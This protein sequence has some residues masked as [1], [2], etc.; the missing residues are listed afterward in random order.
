MGV[1]QDVQI[2]E[3]CAAAFLTKILTGVDP[4]FLDGTGPPAV[5]DRRD[6]LAVHRA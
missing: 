3:L 4:G 6:A 1:G 5:V 2:L